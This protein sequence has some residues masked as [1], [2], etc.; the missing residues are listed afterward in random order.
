MK[1]SAWR[2]FCCLDVCQH[3]VLPNLIFWDL[4]NSYIASAYV[5]I[6]LIPFLD[7]VL[8]SESYKII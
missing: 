6:I 7:L 3:F 2:G 4:K 5:R 1:R 8:N